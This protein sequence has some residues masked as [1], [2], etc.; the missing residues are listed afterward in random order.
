MV[1]D[2]H[3]T[4]VVNVCGVESNNVPVAVNCWVVPLAMLAVSGATVIDAK[5]EVW[6]VATP[7]FPSKVAVIVAVAVVAEPGLL[8]TARPFEPGASLTKATP[9]SDEVQVAY[10]VKFCWVLLLSDNVPIAANCKLV[11]GAMLGA[12]GGA[13]AIDATFEVVSV[14]DPVMFPV[15]A[16]IM[17]VPVAEAAV[18]RP[19]EPVALLMSAMPISDEAQVT[20]VVIFCLLLFE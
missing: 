4:T 3:D 5:D 14:V 18:T 11:V 1:D 12:A 9:V 15:V 20:D 7:D 19:C 16:V 17:V 2:D 8:A 10:V 13:T 6:N